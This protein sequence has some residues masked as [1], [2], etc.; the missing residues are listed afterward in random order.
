M[1]PLLQDPTQSIL[2]SELLRGPRC[3]Q[4]RIPR[5]RPSRVDRLGDERLLGCRPQADLVNTAEPLLGSEHHSPRGPD[6]QG[7]QGPALE[8]TSQ[9]STVLTLLGSP[10]LAHISPLPAPLLSLR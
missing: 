9:K 1:R 10:V 3:S 7:Q 4:N 6:I 2:C 5:V 8:G